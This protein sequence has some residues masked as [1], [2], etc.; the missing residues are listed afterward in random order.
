MNE[1]V[2]NE[3]LLISQ[4]EKR[5]KK[6]SFDPNLT[7]I[8][9]K[10]R[11][12]KSSLLKSIPRAFSA[13][14]EKIG[15]SWL[16]ARVT[17]V[18]KFTICG[19]QYSILQYGDFYAIFDEAKNL[20][21]A[22]DNVT[23]QLGPYLANLFEFELKFRMRE[24]SELISP[25]PAYYLLP[26]Y[27]DQDVGW[28]KN[29][30]SFKYLTQFDSEWKKNLMEYH[31]GIRPNEY[32]KILG[33]ISGLKVEVVAQEK[34]KRIL[35]NLLEQ[36]TSKFK[37]V[38]FNIDQDAFKKEIEELLQHCQQLK[39]I[40][41][42]LKGK[43]VELYSKKS[44]IENQIKVAESALNEARADLRYATITV[45]EDHVECPTCGAT[46][47]NSLPER[48]A[49]AKDEDRCTHVLFK[50]NYA[51]ME[52]KN[53]IEDEK[54]KY[55]QNSGTLAK[56]KKTLESKQEQVV[57]RDL[58]E[59][60]GK[61]ELQNVFAVNIEAVNKVLVEQNHAIDKLKV[62]LKIFD[63]KERKAAI[64]KTFS[65]NMRA[66]LFDLDVHG[67]DQNYSRIDA[68]VSETGSCLPRAL[69]AY[70]FSFLHVMREYSSAA[71][72]PIILDSPNQQAQ[73]MTN[74]PKMMKFIRD[75]RP[76]NTQLI[77]GTEDLCG[78]DF[79]GKIVELHEKQSLL[80]KSDYDEVYAEVIPLMEKAMKGSAD[81]SSGS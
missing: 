38:N 22:T 60:E 29:W 17:N 74:L 8:L 50:L 31:A 26:F 66:F 39:I 23:R 28:M 43:L 16:E 49:I 71:F 1:L 81:T 37:N 72:C 7:V 44:S 4:K 69:L 78:V 5:A 41:E 3:I 21:L 63:D 32:Y 25:P 33:S 45:Y 6:V 48:F 76:A 65:G 40:E 34:D 64:E 80:Q 30:A 54:T 77:L 75:Q 13:I 52:I 19:A 53:Q 47:E 14:P 61:K 79:G 27:I 57:L 59:N 70:Y 56:I 46:Y 12:G 68:K 58:I 10:N 36:A 73:D 67:G 55:S 15:N 35:T 24:S 62:R 20:L 2:L 9:G 18:L 51:L 11:T 42:S